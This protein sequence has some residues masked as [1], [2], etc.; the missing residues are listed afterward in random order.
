MR[1]AVFVICAIRRMGIRGLMNRNTSQQA[2]ISFCDSQVLVHSSLTSQTRSNSI[3]SKKVQ[4]F[5]TSIYCMLILISYKIIMPQ[6]IDIP[7]KCNV[8][9]HVNMNDSINRYNADGKPLFMAGS[10]HSPRFKCE[11]CGSDKLVP[12][13]E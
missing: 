10:P 13:N 1:G 11:K 8:C 2:V 3:Y 9:G 7:V 12:Y 4:S 5:S 6:V